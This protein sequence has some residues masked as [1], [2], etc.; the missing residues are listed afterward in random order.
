MRE[1]NDKLA[2]LR[3]GLRSQETQG[4]IASIKSDLF[5]ALLSRLGYASHNYEVDGLKT[6]TK[7]R[8]Y[9][10]QPIEGT[11]LVLNNEELAN[12]K[13]NNPSVS[14]TTH[15]FSRGYIG[16]PTRNA[17]PDWSDTT[18]SQ[19]ATSASGELT[20]DS[21]SEDYMNRIIFNG[22]PENYKEVLAYLNVDEA[23]SEKIKP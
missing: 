18:S 13:K 4:N 10:T 22:A 12:L 20:R 23:E 11:A 17:R 16:S 9:D 3:A 7:E 8:E 21:I 5:A 14:T 15:T 2:A 6:L 1:I 19:S